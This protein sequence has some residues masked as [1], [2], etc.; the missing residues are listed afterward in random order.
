MKNT[1]KKL[2][3]AVIMKRELCAYFTSPV[4]YIVGALFIL[5]SGIFFFNTF[6]LAGR[7]ELRGFFELL[8]IFFSFLIPALTMRVFSEEKKT[9]TMETLVTLPVKTVDIVIGKY[10]AVLA[11][12]M[13]M[14]APTLFYV[15]TCLLFASSG[16]DAGPIFGGYFGAMLLAAAFSAIG[17]FCSSITGN[18]IVAFLLSLSICMFLTFVTMFA[19]FLPGILVPA[20][21]FISSQGHFRSIARGILDSRD[22][23]YFVS[24][25]AVFV[26]LTVNVLNNERKG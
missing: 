23:L 13:V 5:L 16:I 26:V 20:A 25:S 17:I 12:T 6:F 1:K 8:P 10:L 18:Q 3:C 11:S 7:A 14:L 21:T 15:V 2:P 9:G 19:I 24:V 4:A 22:L